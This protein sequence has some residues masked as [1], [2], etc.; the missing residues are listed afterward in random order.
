MPISFASAVGN[1][2]NRLG[3]LGA[4]V[5]N[6]KNYQSSQFTSMVDPT[7]GVTAQLMGEA[8]IQ[9]IMG[10]S[11]I[12]ILGSVEGASNVAQQMAI[13][14]VNRVVYRDNPQIGQT[15]QSIN[16][17]QSLQEIIRQMG[18]AGASVLAMTVTGTPTGFTGLG[19]GVVNVSTKRPSDGRTLE[20][21]FTEN[22]LIQVRTDSYGITNATE[23]NEA[24]LITGDGPQNDRFAFD[25]PNGSGA[26]K[27]LTAINGSADNTQGN[28]LTN[29]SFEDWTSN[30]PDNWTL[31][32]GSG[33]SQVFE[34]TSITYDPPP[35]KAMRWLGDDATLIKLKQQFATSTGTLGELDTL[36][37]YSINLF[38]RRDAVAAANG[39]LEVALVDSGDNIIQ[40]FAG[41]DNSFSID[42]TQL[43]TVYTAYKG[44]F[45]TPSVLPSSYFLRLRLTTVLENGRSVYF[46]RIS[47]G[48][49]TQLYTSGPFLAV[50]SG[51][52][53]FLIGDY[54]QCQI[55]NSRGSGGTLSTFQTLFGQLFPNEML[56]N[57]LL[58][59]SSSVPTISDTLIG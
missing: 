56:G 18:T 19:N 16:T 20:N 44:V 41:V 15:L 22:L 30:V 32:L 34:E 31:V 55:T 42:L 49:M 47:L 2:F 6:A 1:L 10:S 24:L 53:P 21:A 23:G 51:A 7:T 58:L 43:T 54:A 40:D 28:L 50:H 36:T 59:P 52:I 12:G 45:R 27:T 11:Y 29:S 13:L 4:V 8:D 39:V 46:D 35:N 3:K 9:A 37:Q 48:L 14:V 17:L 25:W 26:T 38:M 5:R 57:E 33:G